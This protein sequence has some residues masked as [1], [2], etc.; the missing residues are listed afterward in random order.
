MTIPAIPSD[1]ISHSEI[2]IPTGMRPQC[3]VIRPWNDATPYVVHRAYVSDYGK[4]E[5]EQ[6]HYCGDL[7]Q[8]HDN[9]DERV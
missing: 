5:Y 1:W 2:K 7:R 9:F 8:A 3:I 6:G 4:W